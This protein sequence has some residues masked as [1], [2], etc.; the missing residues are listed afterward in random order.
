M[1]VI[2]KNI[3]DTQKLAKDLAKEIL[4]KDRLSVVALYGILG[5]GK[6]TFVQFLAK[7]LGVKEK[8]LSPTFIIMKTFA[9]PRRM[10]QFKFLTHIDTY[11]LTSAKDLL[12]LGLKE[13]LKDKENIT[14][15]EWPEKV[16]RYLP[17][18]TMNLYFR[19]M[20]EKERKVTTKNF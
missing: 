8:V 13:I 3:K 16:A 11:R 9:L 6:T 20:G 10:G 18:N 5:A 1:E 14:I 17:K 4:R 2:L 7:A 19:V 15:I 12:E